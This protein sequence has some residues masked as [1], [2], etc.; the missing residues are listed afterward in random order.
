MKKIILFFILPL[1]LFGQRSNYVFKGGVQLTTDG[2]KQLWATVGNDFYF[3]YELGYNFPKDITYLRPGF[4]YRSTQVWG[5]ERLEDITKKIFW[6]AGFG[7]RINRFDF[8]FAFT[9]TKID[10]FYHFYDETLFASPNG[11]YSF[12]RGYDGELSGKFGLIYDIKWISIKT[13]YDLMQKRGTF[14]VGIN[15]GKKIKNFD[16]KT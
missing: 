12:K 8:H 1:S 2:S 15:F 7:T 11:H 4:D 10:H 9:M 6:S 3:L 13:D 14:G 5:H 16:K